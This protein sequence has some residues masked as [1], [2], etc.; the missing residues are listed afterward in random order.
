MTDDSSSREFRE[1]I[2]TL[3]AGDVLPEEIKA[4]FTGLS[5]DERQKRTRLWH[6][7]R[8]L[9][10]D[11]A[12]DEAKEEMAK[13]TARGPDFDAKA[14]DVSDDEAWA[15]LRRRIR[16]REVSEA[17]EGQIVSS[18]KDVSGEERSSRERYPVSRTARASKAPPRSTGAR[19]RWGLFAASVL[20]AVLLGFVWTTPVRV[21]AP[22]QQQIAHELPDGSNVTLAS[23]STL[24]YDRGFSAWLFLDAETRR[25][26]LRGE[27]FFDVVE[28][29]RRFVVTTFN[30]DVEVLGTQFNVRARQD[31]SE[32]AT[33][34]TLLE[35]RLR[36]GTQVGDDTRLL[37]SPGDATVVSD[38]SPPS[39]V[40]TVSPD[41]AAAW[42]TGGFSAVRLP[43]GT[44]LRDVE[45]RFGLQI[46][47]GPGVDLAAPMT[48]HYG[49]VQNAKTIIH[50]V[51]LSEGLQFRPVNGGFKIVRVPETSRP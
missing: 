49:S 4:S 23:G 2:Q 12:D 5:A 22:M 13:D 20:A 36:V 9:P 7:L 18:Q 44:V 43:L 6:L 24:E 48:L 42:R 1:Y 34:V 14:E 21:E 35:G 28:A 46:E 16:D 8:A 47:T 40:E 27:A 38:T 26:A 17:D 33:R 50:D 30:A 37:S 41:R 51:C 15:Q 11:T 10:G 29:Q 32:S 31:E 19:V 25:V 3:A 39:P 45:R